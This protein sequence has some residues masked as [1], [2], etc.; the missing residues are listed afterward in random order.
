M[1]DVNHVDSN[2]L[3]LLTKVVQD[4]N[5]PELYLFFSFATLLLSETFAVQATLFETKQTNTSDLIDIN[6]VKN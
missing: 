1:F 5:S 2:H 4:K 6:P 3:Y